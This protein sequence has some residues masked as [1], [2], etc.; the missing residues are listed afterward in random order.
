MDLALL[1]SSQSRAHYVDLAERANQ[2]VRTTKEGQQDTS[3]LMQRHVAGMR[4]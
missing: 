2:L 3:K 1:I 4:G